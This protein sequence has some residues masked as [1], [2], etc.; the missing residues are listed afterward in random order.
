MTAAQRTAA[1]GGLVFGETYRQEEDNDAR[2]RD[3]GVVNR[4]FVWPRS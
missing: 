1:V 2:A 4:S 3:S